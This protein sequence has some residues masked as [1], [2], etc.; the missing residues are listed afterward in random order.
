MWGALNALK[1]AGDGPCLTK[2]QWKELEAC[3]RKPQNTFGS[4]RVRTQNILRKL[5][6]VEDVVIDG[7]DQCQATPA[8]REALSQAGVKL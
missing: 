8:G 5:L 1:K 4:A 2:V 7:I 3:A 6:L